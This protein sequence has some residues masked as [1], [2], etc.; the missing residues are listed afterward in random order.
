[1]SDPRDENSTT[2]TDTDVA[3]DQ[4][5][6]T[7]EVVTET[8]TVDEPGTATPAA[9]PGPHNPDPSPEPSAFASAWADATSQWIHGHMRNSPLAEATQAWNHVMSKLP[10][11]GAMVETAMSSHKE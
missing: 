2:V 4:D 8:T 7:T 5:G 10:L 1:M 11:L 6:N 9:G 3:T